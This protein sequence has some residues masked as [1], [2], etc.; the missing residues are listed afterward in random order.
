MKKIAWFALSIMSTLYVQGQDYYREGFIVTPENDTLRGFVNDK[1]WLYYP[2]EIEFKTELTSEA[3]KYSTKE[4]KGFATSRGFAFE[5]RAFKYDGDFLNQRGFGVVG[6][7]TSRTP[8]KW[9]DHECFLELLVKGKFSLYKFTDSRDREHFLI[10]EKGSNEL[11]ELQYRTYS[12]QSPG[13]SAYVLSTSEMYKQQLLQY[14]S[15]CGDLKNKILALSYRTNA[16]KSM[17]ES[18]N[19][20]YHDQ[21]QI[22]TPKSTVPKKKNL[23]GVLAN[24]CVSQ[25]SSSL[26]LTKMDQLHYGFG[27]SFEHFSRRSPNRISYYFELKYRM[28]EQTGENPWNDPSTL[29]Y[30]SVKLITMVR[31]APKN[32]AKYFLSAG[33]INGVR[34]NTLLT[35][36]PPGHLEEGELEPTQLETGLCLGIGRRFIFKTNLEVRYE[37]ELPLFVSYFKHFNSVGIVLSKQF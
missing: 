25:V 27:A 33:F 11:V 1:E 18:I 9:V 30:N 2:S 26:V 23:F 34:L 14:A 16:L 17:V 37:F 6:Y 28:F 36:V 10:V 22:V 31:L 13:T 21:Q 19:L 20:C 29:S 12:S 7:P 4:I 24:V 32:N 3:K 35:N 8:E 15:E 5:S